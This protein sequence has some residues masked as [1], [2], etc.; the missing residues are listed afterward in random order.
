LH[1]KAIKLK[2]HGA[3]VEKRIYA[4][5][6]ATYT[7]LMLSIT[8][9]PALAAQAEASPME[10]ALTFSLYNL[11]YF[12]SSMIFGR[13]ADIHGRKVFISA[14]MLIA[15]AA[16]LM[17]Y[18]YW[19]YYSLLTLRIMAGFSAGIF[20]AATI[21]LAHDIKMKMG[22][23]SAF[24]AAG[25]ALGSYFAGIISLFFGLKAT[26]VFSSI[27]FIF[28]YLITWK[29]QDS[30]VRVKH[31]PRIPLEVIKRNWHL[32]LSYIFRHSAATIIWAFWPL[33]VASIGGNSF[34]QAATMGINSTA[35]FF[36]MY[37]YADMRKSTH[38]ILWGLILSSLTFFLYAIITNVWEMLPVQVILA[39][40]WAFLYVGSLNYLTAKNPEKATATGLLNSSI[41]ISAFLGPILGGVF[42]SFIP[43]YRY[44]MVFSGVVALMGVIVFKIGERGQSTNF[45]ASPSI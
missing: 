20:P 29:L 39:A 40:S 31:V 21:S 10:I 15:S 34:W 45:I 32:Y 12:L 41:G 6:I 44:L 9:T 5:Q 13:L 37:F 24:G 26:Y 7:A 28:G 22:K 23:L 38:L 11:A 43:D 2:N 30:G 4:I 36:I 17:Q 3:K 8:Y 19:D 16:F 18:F 14:G 27:V 25:W 35:Q 42:M 33:F 1:G